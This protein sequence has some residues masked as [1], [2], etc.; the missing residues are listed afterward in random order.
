MRG[1]L[2]LML[3]VLLVLLLV[4]LV[5]LLQLLLLFLLLLFLSPLQQ[6]PNEGL[7]ESIDCT[8]SEALVS[9]FSV[10]TAFFQ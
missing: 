6:S 9:S 5:L 4:L 1:R 10:S 2:L 8:W 7:Y 3:L